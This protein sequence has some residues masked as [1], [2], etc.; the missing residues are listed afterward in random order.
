[1]ILSGELIKVIYVEWLEKSGGLR[2]SF[3]K[4][5]LIGII[6]FGALSYSLANVQI[7]N[8]KQD[9]ELIAREV[10]GLRTEV[11]LLRRENAQLRISLEQASKN[12]SAR[13]GNSQGFLVQ[14]ESRINK[15]DSRMLANE[16]NVASLQNGFDAKL[17]ELINQMNQNFAKV[18]SSGPSAPAVPKFSTDY[19]QNGFV[20]KVE[21]GETVSSIAQKYKSKIKWIID[22]N[23]IADPTKV[24]I[25]KELFVPQE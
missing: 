1:M 11:E 10:A 9:L 25:G 5:V 4:L 23:Q 22:A 19:P 15:L 8:M 24:F 12:A 7:A 18:S 3:Y 13:N 20:H 21:K 16:K 2:L 6:Q 17:R 14:I